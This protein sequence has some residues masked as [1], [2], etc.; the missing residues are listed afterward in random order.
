MSSSPTTKKRLSTVLDKH[1]QTT[2]YGFRQKRSTQQALH[3][4]RRIFEK[5][6]KTNTKT[7]MVLLDLEKA[8]DKV[9]RNKLFE[10]PERMNVPENT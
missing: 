8:F 1:L 2:Q 5:G 4:V 6:E 3:Y 10:A 7:L 9:I